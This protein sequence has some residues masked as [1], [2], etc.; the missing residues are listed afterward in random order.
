MRVAGDDGTGVYNRASCNIEQMMMVS[1]FEPS[2]HGRAEINAPAIH[3]RSELVGEGLGFHGFGP[4]F[5]VFQAG[6]VSWFSRA[7]HRQHIAANRTFT[8]GIEVGTNVPGR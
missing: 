8:G 7:Q 1:T 3:G 6:P 4:L 2:R 5:C